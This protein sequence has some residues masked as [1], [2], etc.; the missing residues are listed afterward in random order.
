VFTIRD[1]RAR[2]TLVTLGQRNNQT[3]QIVSGLSE[4]DQVVLHHSDRISDGVAVAERE[5]N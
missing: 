4:G 3:A 1:G 2:S 5:V